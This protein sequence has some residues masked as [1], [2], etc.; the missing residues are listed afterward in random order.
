MKISFLTDKKY[1][2]RELLICTDKIDM[3]AMELMDLLN[4]TVNGTI[5]CYLD[6][7]AE[8]VPLAS[9]I[10]FYSE[11]QRVLARTTENTYTVRRRLYE[12]EEELAGR[13]FVRIS[14][15]EIVNIR[16]IQKL[17]TGISGTIHMYLY[18]G[19]ETYVSRRYVS[20]IRKF[21][22]I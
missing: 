16:K 8:E 11:G 2:R 20:K 5:L 1:S 19:I 13:D 12:L 22:G 10:S 18:G 14:N 21:L 3:S 9:V 6:S 7:C 4:R 17:D 15:S